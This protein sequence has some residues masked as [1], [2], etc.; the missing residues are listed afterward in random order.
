MTEPTCAILQT[1]GLQSSPDLFQARCGGLDLVE[2]HVLGLHY[3]GIHQ[4]YIYDP[5]GHWKPIGRV[6]QLE[7]TT[8]QAVRELPEFPSTG[9][10][11]LRAD[12]VVH[13]QLIGLVKSAEKATVVCGRPGHGAKG[14]TS[15]D[16][17]LDVGDEQWTGVAFFP[18]AVRAEL[19][20]SL[21]N[22][23]ES[24][25]IQTIHARLDKEKT[26][27]KSSEGGFFRK[28]RDR[29]DVR[30]AERLLFHSLRKPQDG[31]IARTFNRPLSL[32]VSRLLAHTHLTPN[33]L[34]VLNA[35]FAV[36]AAL[37]L[38]LGHPVFGWGLWLSGALGGLLIQACSVYD[39]CDG[40]I[41]RVKFQY[42]HLGDW[43][44]TIFDDICNCLFFAGVAAWS[45]QYTGHTYFIW[46]GLA[47]F[48][49]QWIANVVMYYYLIKV[50]GTGNN[51]DYQLGSP[52]KPGGGLV[53]RILNKLKYLT[54]RDFHLFT[55]MILGFAGLLWVGAYFIFVSAMIAATILS[56]QHVQLLLRL[57]R[58]KHQKQAAGEKRDTKPPS[59][60][61]DTKQLSG[62]KRE[63]KH[64]G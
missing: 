46:M 31:L 41:A 27:K 59:D 11:W 15:S 39:G 50:A 53:G 42:S 43:L 23:S 17:F 35:G 34:T 48:V 2:R 64:G 61:R 30:D 56:I 60:R 33:Q 26:W 5:K 44:D 7:G 28:I 40:E 6:L 19:V 21:G 20:K 37:V 16:G 25:D 55:F 47:A 29:R 18:A 32:P 51:Q 38:F 12:A 24:G 1:G 63:G 10:I 52:D 14:G 57:R 13:K 22:D 49:G 3:A 8:V 62:E 58:E 45:Y 9:V 54:K 4:I 36:A